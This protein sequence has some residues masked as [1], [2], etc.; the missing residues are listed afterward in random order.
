MYRAQAAPLSPV[1]TYT[2]DATQ[3]ASQFNFKDF[4]S[5][6]TYLMGSGTRLDGGVSNSAPFGVSGPI[7]FNVAAGTYSE[8]VLISGAIDGASNINTVT[9]DGG[10]GNAASRIITYAAAS[11]SSRFTFQL[12]N[13]QY[14]R[15]RNLTITATGG[16]YGWGVH[17]TGANSGNNHIKNCI[18]TISGTGTTSTT[19]VNYAGI[20]VSGSNT[21]AETGTNADNLEIDSNTIN[22]GHYGI[23]CN[24]NDSPKGI[25]NKFRNNTINNSYKR[26]IHLAAQ[27]GVLVERNQISLRSAAVPPASSY[28]IYCYAFESTSG[29]KN[30]IN[31]NKITSNIGTSGIYFNSCGNNP[32]PKG[33]VSN[34]LIG[35]D[36]KLATGNCIYMTGSND[37]IFAQN[38]LDFNIDGT[39]QTD[40]ALYV[41]SGC[42]GI[43][44]YNNIIMNSKPGAA[45]AVNI[46]EVNNFQV[47]DYNIYYKSGYL[48]PLIN[49]DGTTYSD[50][51]FVGMSG[52]NNN[53]LVK[54]PGLSKT[55][56]MHITNACTNGGSLASYTADPVLSFYLS[57][58]IDG[59]VRN[60]SSPDIGAD[61]YVSATNDL[62][63]TAV[64]SP[65]SP[66]LPGLQ[67]LTVKVRNNGTAP[68][69]SFNVSYIHNGGSP[70][71]IMWTGTLNPCQTETIIFTGTDQ[72]NIGASN[73]LVVYS[74]LP[75]DNN[76]NND[77]IT[78]TIL[79]GLTGNYSIGASGSYTTLIAA[80]ADL[81]LKGITGPVTFTVAANTYTGQVSLNEQILGASAINTIT[82]DGVSAT[83]TII[84]YSSSATA[85][86]HTFL[87]GSNFVILR[88][89]TIRATGTFGWPININ[90]SNLKGIK[91]KSCIIDFTG[92][93]TTATTSQNFSALVINGN[94]TSATSGARIDSLEIDSNTIK[95][96]LY[97]IICVGVSGNSSIG[98]KFRN[99]IIDS[100]YNTALY[101]QNQ[102]G[103]DVQYNFINRKAASNGA[104]G[105]RL[106]NISST[107]T[108]RTI[109][110][111]N[112]IKNKSGSGIYIENCANALGRKGICTNN[113]IGGDIRR[114]S[115]YGIQMSSSNYWFICHNTVVNDFPDGNTNS[116]ATFTA[117]G[118]N[119]ITALNNVFVVTA[120]SQSLPLYTDNTV[121]FDTLDYNLYYKADTVNHEFMYMGTSLNGGNFRG[122][123]N[124]NAVV[125]P[126]RYVSATDLHIIEACNNGIDLTLP[127]TDQVLLALVAK[128]ADGNNR[129]GAGD[130]GAYEL[131][132]LSVDLSVRGMISPDLSLPFV[133]GPKDIVVGVQNNGSSTISSF[134]LKYNNNGNIISE[135]WTGTLVPCDTTSV[136]FTGAKQLNLST[137]GNLSMY[138][139]LPGDLY[140][141]NDT[142]KTVLTPGLSGPYTI[143]TSGAYTSFTAAVNALKSGGVLGAV[144]FTVSPNTYT[145]QVNLNEQ[146]RGASSINTITF[147]GVDS[148]TR[149]LNFAASSSTARHTLWIGSSYVRIK[150]LTIRGSGATYGWPVFINSKVPLTNIQFTKCIIDINST[151]GKTAA[152]ENFVGLVISSSN[153]STTNSMQA[154]SVVID[155]CTFNYGLKGIAG[156]GT[157]E[158]QN[159]SIDC[160]VRNNVFNSSNG[161]GID[162]ANY[163]NLWIQNN[164]IQIS[165][166][167]AFGSGIALSDM[168]ATAGQRML[169]TGNTIYSTGDG[170]SAISIY[171]CVNYT[172]DT[173]GVLANNMIC[174]FKHANGIGIN[175]NQSTNWNICHNSVNNNIG[176]A[177]SNDKGNPLWV[178]S[179]DFTPSNLSVFNNIFSVSKNS[180]SLPLYV[181]NGPNLFDTL[182]NNVYYRADTSNGQFIKIDQTVYSALNFIGAA[183]FNQHSLFKSTGFINDSNLHLPQQNA[184]ANRAGLIVANP[185]LIN[186]ISTDIDGEP[187][188]N[189]PLIGADEIAAPYDFDVAVTALLS[190]VA[191]ISAGTHNLIVRLTNIGN[192]NILSVPFY[193]S[194]NNGAPVYQ[195]WTG[196][197]QKCDTSSIT[198]AAPISL[199]AG[200]NTIK[201][202]SESPNGVSDENKSNDTLTVQVKTA[203]S[204]IYT[205]GSAPTDSFPGFT[206]AVNALNQWGVDGNVIFN[207]RTGTYNEQIEFTRTVPGASTLNTITFQGL[208]RDS[209]V[210][211]FSATG[212][213][214]STVNILD[215]S[216][217]TFKGISFNQ[218]NTTNFNALTLAGN[219]SYIAFE[220]CRFTTTV[221]TVNLNY[222]IYGNNI[223]GSNLTLKNN[224]ISG[225]GGGVYLRGASTS[226]KYKNI[227]F[228]KNTVQTTFFATYDIRNVDTLL[229]TNSYIYLN[230]TRENNNNYLSSCNNSVFA[231]NVVTGTDFVN[232]PQL[233]FFENSTNAAVYHNSFNLKNDNGNG[234]YITNQI[235]NGCKVKNNVF[236]S[237]GSSYAV[238]YANAPFTSAPGSDAEI[239]NNSYY[240]TGDLIH[241][242]SPNV[243]YTTLAPWKAVT[244]K[245]DLNSV[246]YRA[247]YTSTINLVPSNTDSASWSLNGRAVHLGLKN[248]YGAALIANDINGNPRPA[249]YADGAPDIGAFEFTPISIPPA[250]V[251]IPVTP[252]AGGTQ[253]FLFASDTVAK[254]SWDITSAVPPSI[255]V[256]Q[257]SGQ[258]PANIGS[259]TDYMNFSVKTDFD[260]GAYVYKM[261]IPYKE[262]WKGTLP[263]ENDAQ[264]IT[265]KAATPWTL[266][267]TSLVD[268]NKNILTGNFTSNWSVFTGTNLYNPLPVKLSSL[269]ANKVKAD[270]VL[271]WVTATESNNKGFEVERSESKNSNWKA[272]GFVKAQGPLN[273]S[274]NYQFVDLTPFASNVP[275]LYYRLKQIDNNG[276]YEY[277]SIVFVSNKAENAEQVLVYP[278]PFKGNVNLRLSS[279]HNTIVTL[280]LFDLTGRIVSTSTRQIVSGSND[281][282][283]DNAQTL[284]SGIYFI[285]IEMDGV[286][287]IQKLIKE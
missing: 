1:N 168:G 243:V 202:Y 99:N 119:N 250:A 238:T 176:G 262:G 2:I 272:V 230:G 194:V 183:G 141:N 205:I 71:T 280:R 151:A 77:T 137:A 7:V 30:V 17:L 182:D 226:Q 48:K 49:L 47:L 251:A 56:N 154:D 213:K 207:V 42:S 144:T 232:Q 278:N 261:H 9:F 234:V 18:V 220:N 212:A 166:T 67:D 260:A 80:V 286:T 66:A 181:S 211:N 117:N 51:K 23:A 265:S 255:S 140:R 240:S 195:T 163:R 5:A 106:S 104:E 180:A 121:T 218:I 174:G 58:D 118:C 152:N 222:A 86:R 57:K 283:I 14:V 125:K 233:V 3:A 15:L 110:N 223:S 130:M 64:A 287:Q 28:G 204:G 247:G 165:K 105:I 155:S 98:N 246:Y 123:L 82:F 12:N 74:E 175:V 53:S 103:I 107:N 46:P 167:S 143:G 133:A 252:V 43:E 254:I 83:N 159:W 81:K 193:Y 145:E 215:A 171:K 275:T 284:Q 177:T 153:S 268:S 21:G 115:T 192:Q 200:T 242:I 96:G 206:S 55:G 32:G 75:A 139:E 129:T 33:L 235:L 150:N 239:D 93:G 39:S 62:E 89:L 70:K 249:T 36:H 203:M 269:K 60:T 41:T 120:P 69:G 147:D 263:N 78:T 142:V 100:S 161:A 274:N 276:K 227:I 88:N 236:T 29:I 173:K 27:D 68:I 188:T 92:G 72:I 245:E 225:G 61:E 158:S 179:F 134:T 19:S 149:I 199:A 148:L 22:F 241:Q 279:A 112:K 281:L 108:Y 282:E 169:I 76:L 237:R 229:F 146:I 201:V 8:Q 209:A 157:F 198:F 11:S 122:P 267:I 172:P 187:R 257:F 73:T 97:G 285:S 224:L 85:S 164:V 256:R 189:P 44:L 231:N 10:T 91:V 190:P 90:G 79:P 25:N 94:V 26:G 170:G 50:D 114:A 102:T 244:G 124:V 186:Y 45:L 208:H 126:F 109:I 54:S 178:N 162:L 116:Y 87:V 221:P 24:G 214:P 210:I 197:L 258:K 111:A 101:I 273:T 196:S 6:V 128:D 95:Y 113:I 34:N 259:A 184:C 156:Y 136:V 65:V 131:T 59:D 264:L 160:R 185:D 248:V 38:T 13:V 191:P 35:G 219:C 84:T 4:S 40:A 31:A 271:N 270:V 37:W 228:D 135:T 132:P 277:S 253:V 52:L 216:Y 217:L 16:T 127:H 63:V 266:E 138:I 20:V